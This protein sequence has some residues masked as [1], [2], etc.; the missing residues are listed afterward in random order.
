MV[1][2]KVASMVELSPTLDA[3]DALHFTPVHHGPGGDQ[4]HA[5]QGGTRQKNRQGGQH[6]HGRQDPQTRENAGQGCARSRGI[7]H[8][9]AGEG[10]R[11]RVSRKETR[12]H[13]GQALAHE[14][15][16][17]VQA[18]AGLGRD[19]AGNGDGLD[20]TDGGHG[21]GARGEAPDQ[22][23]IKQGQI[24]QR[25]QGA[26]QGAQN[27]DPV[28]VQVPQAGHAGGG[29]HADQGRGPFRAVLLDGKDDAHRAQSDTHAQEVGLIGVFDEIAYRHPQL[30]RAGEIK[31]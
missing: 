11:H 1:A 27:L 16:I 14:L 8:H 19:G 23:E 7:V 29:E 20:Q 15:L 30:G 24:G 4:Q 13:V 9:G 18:L 5:S 26:R 6:Q 28:R 22:V 12:R 21:Q 25:G 10:A 17:A 2:A 3:Q 31:S